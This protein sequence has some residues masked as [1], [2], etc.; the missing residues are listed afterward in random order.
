MKHLVLI[1]LL[2]CV[3]CGPAY[4]VPDKS[5]PKIGETVWTVIA[6]FVDAGEISDSTKL[7][8]V[9]KRLKQHG[10]LDDSVDAKLKAIW[11]D[12]GLKEFAIG[13]NDSSK[14]RAI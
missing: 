4:V 2:V 6:D 1:C 12:Y 3:G 10:D 14:L 5:E 9:V 7:E 13:K 11:S 8:L